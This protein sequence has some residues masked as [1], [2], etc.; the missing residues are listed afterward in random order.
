MES[1]KAVYIN[2]LIKISKK[3]KVKM[4]IISTVLFVGLTA[5]AIYLLNNFLGIRVTGSSDFTIMVLTILNYSIFPLFISFICIDM[6][7][8]EF[9][10]ET[11]KF[12]LTGPAPRI[13]V[14]IG[15]MCAVA[16]YLMGMLLFVMIVSMFASIFVN[17]NILNPLKGILAYTMAF[18]P[19]F[20]FASVVVLI[21]NILKGTT[22]AFMFS[23]F[24]LLLFNGI[25]FF[26]PQVKS[27]LFTSTFDWYRLILGSY[28]N[29]S[30]I[31]RVFLILFGY[32]IMLLTSSFYLFEKK[33]I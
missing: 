3:K 23:I 9:V 31:I 4:T 14:F 25:G 13:K 18:I 11:I 10:D 2:E 5:I 22:S 16:S 12:T 32:C 28:I 19:I 33:D 7:S 6:F 17:E 15:K 26:F 24:I 29:Y 20:V 21:S 27:F 30:K 8:G 1:L